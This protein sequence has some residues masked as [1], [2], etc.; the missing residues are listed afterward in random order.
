MAET[1]DPSGKTVRA[2]TSLGELL[3]VWK[4]GVARFRAVP[5][6]APPVG[7]RRFVPP[8][9]PAP[10]T[11]LRDATRHGP[12]A[13]Q[14]PS[15]LRLAMGEFAREQDEDCLT[16]TIATPAA[17]AG[18]R[19]V[20]VWLH[21]GAWLSGAGSLDW[22][23]GAALAR[24]GDVVVVGVNYRL[25]PLGFLHF[26]DLADGLMGLRDMVAALRFVRDQIAAF[27]GDAGNVT[28]MG[29]SAGGGA[30][31]RLLEMEETRGL[32][33]RAIVQS[34]APRGG[35]GSV[36]ATAR[37]RRLMQLLEIDPDAADAPARLRAAP[38]GPMIALQMQIARENARF[39]E[40]EP[41][42]P[43]VF[44]DF[45]SV[46]AF[47]D[48]IAR[49]AAERGIDFILGTTR[50]EMH[51]FFGA[52]PAMALPDPEAVAERFST[53][54][55]AADAIEAYRRRRPGGSLRDLL[56]DL[57]TDHRFLFPLLGLAE[58][59]ARTGWRAHVYEF[60]WSPPHSPWQA[61]HC[62]EL[63]FVFGTLAAWDAPMLAGMDAAEYA[64][65]SAAMM[66]AWTRFARTG[67][68]AGPDLPWPGYDADR[69]QTMRFGRLVGIVGDL[70]GVGWRARKASDPQPA[71]K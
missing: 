1:P 36:E 39:A 45:G 28:L 42:F 50:E 49:A 20:L 4:E 67:D 10:W 3:G 35:P 27:G 58:R 29:Q 7:P 17:D 53:L 5:Y 55:G 56:A 24:S 18:R 37:G 33:H 8:A 70:A 15:R 26:P 22:Y 61:C 51:A 52:D 12:I 65:L 21:G 41:A 62:I 30:I 6:A 54:A 38:V 48:R 69:R 13:P 23:D 46:E 25:G 32:F 40:I 31:L 63:P 66:A 9:P 64:G 14:P 43:P 71:P 68:P 19:P 11:G 47:S 59:I 44:D 34:G 2:R 60:D 16:L 57:V